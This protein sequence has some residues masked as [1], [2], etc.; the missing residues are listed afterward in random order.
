MSPHFGDSNIGAVTPALK[1]IKKERR[2]ERVQNIEYT[3]NVFFRKMLSF[4]DAVHVTPG[5]FS[6]YRKSAL[7]EIGGFDEHNLTEDMDVALRLHKAGYRIDNELSAVSYTLCPQKWRGL[8]KQRLRWYRGGISNSVKHRDILFN[9]RYGNLGM[10]YMPVNVLAIAAIISIF[11]TIVWTAGYF[12]TDSI[13]KFSM[14]NWDVGFVIQS[15]P[16]TLYGA[17]TT[18]IF[19]LIIGLIFGIAMIFIS[20]GFV[21]DDMNRS[22]FSYFFYLL[23][24]PLILMLFWTIAFVYEIFRFRKRW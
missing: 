13:T 12:I 14:I 1:L 2:I 9:K 24:Y 5:V 3:F 15:I 10:F 8:F 22:K 6:I 11:V 16:A 19:L 7:Q 21:G 20:F 17:L 4:L 18:P 23:F